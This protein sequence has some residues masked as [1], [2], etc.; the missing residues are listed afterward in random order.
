[1]SPLEQ[2]R[3]L[4]TRKGAKC[5]FCHFPLPAGGSRD[6][7]SKILHGHDDPWQSWSPCYKHKIYRKLRIHPLWS[8]LD[9]QPWTSLFNYKMYRMP[10]CLKFCNERRVV[11][12]VHVHEIWCKGCLKISPGELSMEP[13]FYAYGQNLYQ[14]VQKQQNQSLM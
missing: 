3:T 13:F 6:L 5:L 12:F 2:P 8:W 4:T 1:M 9:K 7:K 11:I 10:D 14:L